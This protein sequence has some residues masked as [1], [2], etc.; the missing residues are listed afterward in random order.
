MTSIMPVIH[1]SFIIDV[2]C[3]SVA[4]RRRERV[5]GRDG[6]AKALPV[7][8]TGIKMHQGWRIERNRVMAGRTK[9]F[10]FCSALQR[11]VSW[12]IRK[13]RGLVLAFAPARHY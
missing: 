12:R 6:W 5:S 11:F 2:L 7:L 1:H 10:R 8:E 9:L 3:K 13:G 4:L